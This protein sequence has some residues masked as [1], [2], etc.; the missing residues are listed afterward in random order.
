M[1]LNPT[2]DFHRL[3]ELVDRKLDEALQRLAHIEGKVKKLATRAEL[4][5]AK[6]ELKQAIQ[7]E[8]S[9]VAADIQAL[10]DQ[11]ARGEP[12]TDQDLA[13]IQEAI[14]GVHDVDP[15]QP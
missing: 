4:D 8:A 15:D 10:R 5:A 6:A 7:D 14:A 9:Q 2:A 3:I 13:D 11:I 1:S 12:I